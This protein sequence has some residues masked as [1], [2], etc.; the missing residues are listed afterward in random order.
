MTATFTA[1]VTR[2]LFF[3][4]APSTDQNNSKS[5]FV[6]ITG[7]LHVLLVDNSD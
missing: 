4:V 6:K 7:K 2:M 5:V 1:K 3:D